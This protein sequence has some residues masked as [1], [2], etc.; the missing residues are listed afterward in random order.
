MKYHINEFRPGY[1]HVVTDGGLP[2]Y[3]NERDGN[4]APLV[5]IDPDSAKECAERLNQDS[6]HE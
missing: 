1:W 4:D 6:E 3:D 5:F 2:V